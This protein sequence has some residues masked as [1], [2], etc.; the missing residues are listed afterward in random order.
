[1]STIIVEDEYCTVNS[2]QLGRPSIV[3]WA[4][5]LLQ[6]AALN[7]DVISLGSDHECNML[8]QAYK[9]VTTQCAAGISLTHAEATTSALRELANLSDDGMGK[10]K[11]TARL[12]PK[13]K[14]ALIFVSD[15]STALCK[16]NRRGAFMKPD[17]NQEVN[18]ACVILGWAET[19]YTMCWGKTLAWITWQVEEHIKELRLNHPDM[20]IDVICWWCGNEISGKWGCIPT[21]LGIGLSYRDA[22]TSTEAVAKKIRRSADV[23]AA[24]TG[25]PDI[26]FVKVIGNVDADLFQ[27][28][29]AYSDFNKAMFTESSPLP[30]FVEKL[31]MYDSFHAS[32]DERNRSFFQAYIHATLSVSKAEW[33]ATSLRHTH[34]RSIVGVG[35]MWTRCSTDVAAPVGEQLLRAAKADKK[36]RIRLLGI[37]VPM[38]ETIG[39]PL[40]PVRV[41]ISQGHNEKLVGNNPDAD[42][43]LAT[44]FL[45]TL[46][47]EEAEE[48]SSIRGVTVLPKEDTPTKLYHRTNEKGMRGIIRD[49]MVPGSARSNRAHNYLSPYRLNDAKY[50]GGMRSNQ[51]IEMVIDTIRAIEAGCTFFIT[52]TDGVLTRDTIPPDCIVSAIDTSQKDKPLY[53]AKGSEA[54]R[55]GEPERTFRAKRDYEEA[56][57]SSTAAPP[58]AA[59]AKRMPTATQKPKV[60]DPSEIEDTTMLP[61]VATREGEPAPSA[62]SASDD[63]EVEVEV[64][65]DEGDTTDAGE[66]ELYPLGSH[67]C[68]SCHAVVANGMLFCLKCHAP[69]S[70]ETAKT[71]K[72]FFE[73][74][75]LR[76]RILAAAATGSQKPIDALL[77]SDLRGGD[78][79]KKR[80]QMSAEAVV[81]REAKDRRTRAAKMNYPS[82]SERWER[83]D[84][85]RT[86]MMQEGRNLEDMQ[87][88]DYLSSAILPDPGRTEEQRHLR[89]GANYS[90]AA[91][92]PGAAPAKL[93]FF[94]HCE[95]EPLR[96]LR[97][98]DN[99]SD[100]PIGVTY[101]GTFLS[102][103][104]YAEIALANEAA[105]RILTFDGEVRLDGTTV[106]GITS[107]LA[108]VINDSLRSAEGQR[109]ETERLAEQNRQVAA[110]NRYSQTGRCQRG[111]DPL[112]HGYTQ[113]QWDE[114]YRRQR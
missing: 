35:P 22:T 41:R 103:K 16:K 2:A 50:M 97:F 21:R 19:R 48:Q 38:H 110:R 99:T 95:V 13:V 42:L 88:F 3:K 62:P 75:K 57:S 108:A 33:I 56:A 100:V 11:P 105:R 29:S 78:G 93:V 32:E 106:D 114:Y 1:M 109:D 90:S 31:E 113:A 85:F 107:E 17:C 23:L 15:S 40:F 77:T 74:A 60:I 4:K 69:Q 39:Q 7:A 47:K 25:E 5:L 27:L 24:L 84:Q 61:A 92:T 46:S 73:N 8:E 86:R 14:R 45:S 51:P 98:I 34:W 53:V 10:L 49:G 87:K 55:E 70:D 96:T 79:S 54:T 89:A 104:I 18:I 43:F 101:M 71:T 9:C 36:G 72:K 26:G 68:A 112:Y 102:P 20:L 6:S 65:V 12:S 76:K 67:P 64:E 37:D 63:V 66:E 30:P 82:V 58:K 59:A 52:E 111:N 28:H 81:I 83:D 80:G 91:T 44:K 94:A